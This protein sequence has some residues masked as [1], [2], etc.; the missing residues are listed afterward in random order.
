[1]AV[2]EVNA[3][4]GIDGRPVA[5]I[6]KDDKND[7]DAAVEADKA[8]IAQGV[9][10]I[11]GHATSSMT[12]AALPVANAAKIVMIGPTTSTNSL[13]GIDDYFFRVISPNRNETDYFGEL[14]A[15]R[16]GL[17]TLALVY[18]L[19]NKGYTE[20]W[21]R[22]FESAFSKF[23]GDIIATVS[24]TSGKDVDYIGIAHTVIDAGPDGIMIVGG[25]IDTAMICQQFKKAGMTKPTM[26][27]GW[28]K[29]EELIEYGGSAA[30]G[31]LFSDMFNDQ[32][33]NKKFLDFRARFQERFGRAPDFAAAY[34]YESFQLLANALKSPA[35]HDDLKTRILRQKT[36]DGLQGVIEMD[37]YGDAKRKRFLITVKNGTFVAVED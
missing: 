33:Q 17:K 26:A 35:D 12:I 6:V 16:I 23:G 20:D 11:I 18:D 27:A 2:E 10:A 29:T 4:G 28:S 1:M 22:H 19:S 13:T 30:E 36:M 7:A 15:K 9:I 14:A 25:A 34:G 21:C 37:P 3:S 32:S 31:L 24:F 5:L 8:L